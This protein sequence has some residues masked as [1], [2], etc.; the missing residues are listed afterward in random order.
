[1]RYLEKGSE[2]SFSKFCRALKESNQCFLI[3]VMDENV[4]PRARGSD[5]IRRELTGEASAECTPVSCTESLSES[6]AETAVKRRIDD[7]STVETGKLSTG[8]ATESTQGFLF[9]SFIVK[10]NYCYCYLTCF[11]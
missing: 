11:C 3:K 2:S 8:I 7:Y 5:E 1:M 10:Y 4:R 6:T 9:F